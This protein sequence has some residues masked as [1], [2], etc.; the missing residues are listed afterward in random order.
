METVQHSIHSINSGK[1]LEEVKRRRETIHWVDNTDVPRKK[2]VTMPFF[3]PP[4]VAI[5]TARKDIQGLKKAAQHKDPAIRQAAG[6]ALEVLT[7]E[8][9]TQQ[10]IAQFKGN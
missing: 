9:K 6:N 2:E 1:E 8:P 10:R 5:L 7:T 3:G 4:D